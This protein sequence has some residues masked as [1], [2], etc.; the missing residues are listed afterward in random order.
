MGTILRCAA[1]EQVLL[2]FAE[3]PR[4]IRLDMRGIGVLAWNL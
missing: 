3:T 1:C 2:R 4:G